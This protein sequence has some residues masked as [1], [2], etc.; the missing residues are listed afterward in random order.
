MHVAS[1]PQTWAVK[2][3]ATLGAAMRKFS[4]QVANV[5]AV[6]LCGCVSS[7]AAQNPPDDLPG[8][9]LSA[10]DAGSTASAALSATFVAPGSAF[11]KSFHVTEGSKRYSLALSS[12]LPTEMSLKHP[13]TVVYTL[14]TLVSFKS[15]SSS[16]VVRLALLVVLLVVLVLLQASFEPSD[17]KWA[18]AM[19]KPAAS[20]SPDIWPAPIAALPHPNCS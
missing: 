10:D 12:T 3:Q 15:I 7:N 2:A 20:T 9:S 13:L 11:S 18:R 17:E 19:S 14:V 16:S 4:P 5:S 6:K 8:A 1:G